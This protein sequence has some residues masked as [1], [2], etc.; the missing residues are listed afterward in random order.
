MTGSK[1]SEAKVGRG[2]ATGRRRRG[3]DAAERGFAVIAQDGCHLSDDEI[4]GCC[5]LGKTQR[6]DH[7]AEQRL[8]LGDRHQGFESVTEGDAVGAGEGIDDA[9]GPE[10]V[11]FGELVGGEGAVVEE[12][13]AEFDRVEFGRQGSEVNGE[14]RLGELAF[15]VVELDF[16]LA[17]FL[18]PE[19]VG[20]IGNAFQSDPFGAEVFGE[21]FVT[22]ATALAESLLRSD[23]MRAVRTLHFA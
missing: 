9:D 21:V 14:E 4:G 23:G 19:T 22:E 16:E 18:E 1:W 13:H 20:G 15:E 3:V 2:A 6:G 8:D 12:P 11:A 5:P 10:V 7:V 17:G